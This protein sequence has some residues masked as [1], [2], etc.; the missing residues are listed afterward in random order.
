MLESV[1]FVNFKVLRDTSLPLGPFTLIVGPNS[2]GKST[3]LSAFHAVQQA[4]NHAFRDVATAGLERNEA[5]EVSLRWTKPAD[6]TLVARWVAEGRG[7]LQWT[8]QDQNHKYTADLWNELVRFQVFSLEPQVISQA[9]ALQPGLQLG[10]TGEKLAGVLD[11]LRDKVPEKFEALNQELGRLL[12]EFDRIL[13]ETPQNGF[14]AFL[15]RARSGGHQIPARD[16]SHGTLFALTLLTL[17]HLPEPPPLVGIEDPDRGIHPR[18]LREIRDAL[19]RLSYPESY[20]ENRAPVQVVVTTHSPYFLDLFKEH[21]EEVV[22]AERTD[23]GA[24]FARLADRPDVDE[25]LADAALGE[26]WYSGVL[27]GV[28][29]KP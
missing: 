3:A 14:R 29:A 6:L 16:L 2:S 9:V 20:G 28:P 19:Y 4:H 5:V 22:I 18:L 21:P 25:I 27:G 13:F 7:I 8:G 23:A 12:P 17:A 1:R 24:R 10:P 15:L 26:V 11:A